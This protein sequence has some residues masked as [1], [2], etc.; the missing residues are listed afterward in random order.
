MIG[1]YYGT[2]IP[3][4]GAEEGI[5]FVKDSNNKYSI[6]TKRDKNSAAELYGETNE[7]TSKNLDDLWTRI[8]E[9]FVAKT[10][11]VAGLSMEENISL[12]D[13]RTA[14]ELQGLAYQNEA[15]GTLTDYVT[16]VVGANY[17][18]T[19]TVE[20]ILGYGQTATVISKGNY[21]PKGS[22]QGSATA[23]GSVSLQKDTNGF[24]VSGSVSAPNITIVPSTET[25]K[26][27]TGVGTLPSY[28][29]AQYTAPS[30]SSGSSSFATEGVTASID[31][32]VLKLVPAATASAI[33]SVSLDKGSYTAA[34][35]NPGTLPTIDEEL[36]VVTGIDSASA[37]Q[38]VFTGDKI[39]ATFTGQSSNIS[40]TFAGTEEE[41]QVSGTYN[42]AEVESA[43]FEG[44]A[45][46][47]KPGLKKEN[48]AVT[49]Q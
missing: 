21:T 5:Y 42:Q 26:Q 35:F 18:P 46:T 12:N 10:F 30:L 15:T 32:T 16:E 7:L 4:T 19:G 9:N 23:K 6:Y 44:A 22:V 27:I 13:M 48:K 25:I 11:T 38:P 43:T 37:S 28:T 8:G 29:P 36:S 17:T 3:G 40:A 14:L 20:V 33:S 2:S 49:V 24:A 41:I 39:S 47:I 34:T 45:A 1:F 31:G